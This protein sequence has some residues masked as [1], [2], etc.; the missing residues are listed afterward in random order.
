MQKQT[1]KG[2]APQ[3]KRRAVELF[4]IELNFRPKTVENKRAY[5]RRAKHR[6]R[7]A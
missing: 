3:R 6:T 4:S 5:R 1:I 2:Q 7:D